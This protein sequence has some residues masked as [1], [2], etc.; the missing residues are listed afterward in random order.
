M[1]PVFL[2]FCFR[3]IINKGNISYEWESINIENT[4]IRLTHTDVLFVENKNEFQ[5]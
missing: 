2:Q 1:S 4:N 3:K 5:K